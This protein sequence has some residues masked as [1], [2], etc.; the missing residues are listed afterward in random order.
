MDLR[1]YL[2]G[3]I[4]SLAL[5]G[6]MGCGRD[7]SSEGKDLK[8]WHEKDYVLDNLSK[9]NS[10]NDSYKERTQDR[11]DEW[12]MGDWIFESSEDNQILKVKL[13]ITPQ[14]VNIGR[15]VFYDRGNGFHELIR[16]PLNGVQN[17]SILEKIVF[18]K[19][20]VAILG[21]DEDSSGYLLLR[22][23]SEEGLKLVPHEGKIDNNL[24]KY[25]RDAFFN[26]EDARY[27]LRK[28]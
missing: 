6:V 13:N 11:K 12:Y 3:G 17:M 15:S 24:S 8:K 16:G 21:K 20:D 2:V 27:F 10:L 19:T 28:K 7:S 14:G 25:K 1:K 9:D 22:R 4:A 23:V 18:D 26:S 5:V